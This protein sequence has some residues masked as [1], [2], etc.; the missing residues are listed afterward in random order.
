MFIALPFGYHCKSVRWSLLA[1]LMPVT[2]LTWAGCDSGP[3]ESLYDPDR[4]SL[5]DPVID[6]VAP[7]DVA[8]AGVD[9]VTITGQN[10]SAELSDNLVWF[11]QTHAT[12]LEAATTQLRV[13]PPNTP[14]ANL[15]L[16][17]A[18]IGAENFSNS[19]TYSLEAAEKSFGQIQAFEDVFSITTDLGGDVYI[20]LFSDSRPVGLERIT[21]DGE[22]SR[23]A[24][25]GFGWADIAFGPDRYLYSVRPVRAIFR[26]L[27]GSSQETWLVIPESTLR[28]SSVAVDA[29]GN[30]W[31]AGNNAQIY[32]IAPDKSWKSYAFADEIAD[33]A[34]AES[35]L[36]VAG[37]DNGVHKVWRLAIGADRDLGSA[38]EI[39]SVTGF[40]GSQALSV[41]ITTTGHV[42]VGTDAENP[43][44]LVAPDG[45]A[46]SLFPGILTGPAS[47]M[48]W[49]PSGYLYMV[50]GRTESLNPEITRINTR[51]EGIRFF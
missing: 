35:H 15:E 28:L 4:A 12:V 46:E 27:E 40:N 19:V 48:A 43:I 24:D 9:I 2:M 37:S 30:V 38:E 26:F 39:V 14:M 23:F 13:V 44:I 17:I 31:S 1:L 45:T 21:A 50:R 22:R 25:T 3:G 8:L 34:L 32:S 6:G 29:S 41:A 11:G 16:R 51:M 7:E 18:V 42:L 36:F 33:L 5:A 49:G 10:F 47:K 20:S